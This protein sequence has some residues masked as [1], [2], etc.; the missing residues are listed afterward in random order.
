[1]VAKLDLPAPIAAVVAI[2]PANEGAHLPA[3][4]DDQRAEVG[5]VGQRSSRLIDTPSRRSRVIGYHRP[6]RRSSPALDRI[7]SS[8]SRTRTAS[9]SGAEWTQSTSVLS[10]RARARTAARLPL[11]LET[12]TPTLPCLHLLEPARAVWPCPIGMRRGRA[13]VNE[14][15]PPMRLSWRCRSARRRRSR[16][17]LRGRRVERPTPVPHLPSEEGRTGTRHNP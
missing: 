14:L 6:L 10:I 17:S 2:P 3:G 4:H 16:C 7:C 9:N 15:S 8:P 5:L 12:T 1:M 11:Q 13:S